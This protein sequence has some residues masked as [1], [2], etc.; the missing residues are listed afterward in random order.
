MADPA[1]APARTATGFV[2]KRKWRDLC[3]VLIDTYGDTPGTQATIQR[4]AD[5][6]NIDPSAKACTPERIERIN[7][8]RTR[9]VAETGKSMY[10]VAGQQ[11]YYNRRRQEVNAATAAAAPPDAP[12]ASD[13]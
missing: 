13:P 6:L 8:W 2:S 11:S 9:T 12:A 7:A 5:V 10:V 1:P 4:I 3:A